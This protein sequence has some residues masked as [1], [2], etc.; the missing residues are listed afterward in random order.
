MF[1]AQL[2]SR[3]PR[4]VGQVSN[5]LSDSSNGRLETCPTLV[6]PMPSVA[7]GRTNTSIRS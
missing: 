1:H 5:L 7:S 6:V 2:C 4:R 3:A